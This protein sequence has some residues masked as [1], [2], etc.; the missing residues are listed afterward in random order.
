[1]VK[2]SCFAPGR[3]G[4]TNM[5]LATRRVAGGL[6]GVSEG[7]FISYRRGDQPGFTGRLYDRLK[8]AFPGRPLFMDV[9]S[10]PA[11][12]DFVTVLRGAVR[13]SAVML[14]VI[15]DGWLATDSEGRPRIAQEDDYVHM[16]VA[17]A[18][19]L[20]KRVI[21]VVVDN[22]RMVGEADLPSML[23][24]LARRNAA[25]IRHD[26]FHSDCEVLIGAITAAFAEAT[27]AAAAPSIARPAAA[28]PEPGARR[29]HWIAIAGG[30]LAVAVA[31]VWAAIVLFVQPSV[32]AAGGVATGRDTKGSTTGSG[33][34]IKP[35]SVELIKPGSG[36]S[37]IN[38]GSGG[39]DKK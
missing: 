23:K 11:G 13:E 12:K 34:L 27:P 17:L 19:A 38:P 29:T 14:V 39:T 2:L 7:T 26:R 20:D 25:R 33:E 31:V 5:G 28:A 35:G 36:G 16:E 24:P 21:P 37:L 15:G 9:D 30:G 22:A 1:M 32:D 8:Q 6:R 18:L 10:I 3:P 4:L